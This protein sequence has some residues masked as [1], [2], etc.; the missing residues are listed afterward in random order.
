MANLLIAIDLQVGWRHPTATEQAMKNAIDFCH[1]FSGDK[2]HCRFTND[3]ESLFYTQ[4]HWDRFSDV[5]DTDEIPEAAALNL[6]TY[7]RSTYNCVNHETAPLIAKADAVYI[8]GVF[9][10][11]SIAATAMAIFDMNVPVYVVRDCVATLHGSDVHEAALKSLEHAIGE[12]NVIPA[13]KVI[14]PPPA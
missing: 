12:N 11:I 8:V 9:T 13:N 1:R 2:I 4:L 6:P 7:W 14:A 10:D 5:S 3:P